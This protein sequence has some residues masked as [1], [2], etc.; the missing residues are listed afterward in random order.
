MSA[1]DDLVTSL[2]VDAR[3]AEQQRRVNELSK[4]SLSAFRN[5]GPD[6]IQDELECDWGTL[7]SEFDSA[8]QE[9]KKDT[10]LF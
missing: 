7:K 5:R 8:L 2:T 1:I 9:V 3:D 10:G 6:G 4:R